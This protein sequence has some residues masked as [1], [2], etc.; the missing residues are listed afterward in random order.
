MLPYLDLTGFSA[1]ST[2]PA[3]DVAAVEASAPGY[4][5]QRIAVRT[6]YINSRLRKRYGNSS[7]GSALPLG[8]IAPT[9]DAVGTQA[10]AVALVGRPALGSLQLA[11]AVV[12]AGALGAATFQWSSDGEQTWHIGPTLAATAGSGPGVT[13]TGTSALELPELL[14]VEITAN[15]ALGAALFQW[16]SDGGNTWTF[17]PAMASSGT[18]PPPVFLSGTSVLAQPSDLQVQIT[19]L[20]PLGTAVYRWSQDGGATWTTGLQTSAQVLP[21]GQTG[22]SVSFSPGT[23]AVN[24]AYQGQGIATS[25]RVVAAGTGLTLGFAAGA[26]TTADAYAGQGILTAASVTL[27]GTGLAAQFIAGDYSADNV[28][29][30]PTPVPETV[31]GW[32]VSLV[33]VDVMRKRGTNP[34]DPAIVLLVKE[35]DEAIAELKEAAD[36]KDGLF[37]LPVNEDADSAVTTGGPQSYSEASPYVWT[38]R[39][40]CEGRQQ[41]GFG[42]GRTQ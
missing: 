18:T 42:R 6:S 1:R 38:D 39:E 13:C 25:S 19:T 8:Q 17:A 16:S 30:A 2:I 29:R 14:E 11:L 5:E 15:G 12:L 27:P 4:V 26:Y 23:Y 33:S 24:D 3:T 40:A 10:P 22:L 35:F 21:L 34:Q 41:D 28:Y 37:D 20:G 32:I 7:N 36:S 31:L 9:L